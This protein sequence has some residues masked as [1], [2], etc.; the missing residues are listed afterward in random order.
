V[1]LAY[2]RVIWSVPHENDLELHHHGWQIVRGNAYA[3]WAV[4]MLA[5]LTFTAW[6]LGRGARAAGETG[7]ADAT[8]AVAPAE[9]ASTAVLSI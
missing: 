9:A 2:S 5:L 7:D 3:G 4:L 8:T 6:R 1:E